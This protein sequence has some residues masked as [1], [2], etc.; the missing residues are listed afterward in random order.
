[1]CNAAG[2]LA[3]HQPQE[4][5]VNVFGQERERHPSET[6][7]NAIVFVK[8]E[9]AVAT[10][11]DHECHTVF[12]VRVPVAQATPCAAV[13]RLG[14]EQGIQVERGQYLLLDR[15]AV[16]KTKQIW[17]IVGGLSEYR[18]RIRLAAVARQW[19]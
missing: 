5:I 10:E 4:N 1:M 11:R 19:T 14:G 15:L 6:E 18:H 17:A 9:A 2:A 8:I 16:D 12:L 3:R 7:P 13:P